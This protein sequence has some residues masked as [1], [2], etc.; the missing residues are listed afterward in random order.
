MAKDH[1]NCPNAPY[2]VVT[3][4]A[5]DLAVEEELGLEVVALVTVGAVPMLV[6]GLVAEPVEEARVDSNGSDVN[7]AVR[8]V[9]F[10]QAEG[11]VVAVPETKLTAAHYERVSALNERLIALSVYLIE[12]PIRCILNNTNNTL[13]TSPRRVDRHILLAEIA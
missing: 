1:E 8:P 12:N 13:R 9:T 10:V 7:C 3:V 4:A 2:R 11:V 5:E 6:A